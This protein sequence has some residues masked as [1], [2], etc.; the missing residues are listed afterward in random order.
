MRGLKPQATPA[1]RPVTRCKGNARRRG[2]RAEVH[3]G[4]GRGDAPSVRNEPLAGEDEGRR[5]Q[6][7]NRWTG[8]PRE[9]A[10][11]FRATC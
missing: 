6:Q 8:K 1:P 2:M 9:C 11:L 3:P 4:D 5:E 10:G 7:T